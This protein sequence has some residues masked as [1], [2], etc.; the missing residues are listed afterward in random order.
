MS[1]RLIT[2]NM[3]PHHPKYVLQ[4]MYVYILIYLC[5]NMCSIQITCLC[6]SDIEYVADFTFDGK[7]ILLVVIKYKQSKSSINLRLPPKSWHHRVNNTIILCL[8]FCQVEGDVLLSIYHLTWV[9][10]QPPATQTYNYISPDFPKYSE[11]FG[12]NVNVLEH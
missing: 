5:I 11:N 1:L 3:L 7:V 8:R 12:V 10:S 4:L 6:K 2:A 9:N